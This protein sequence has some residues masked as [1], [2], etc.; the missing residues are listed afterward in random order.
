MSSSEEF[1]IIDSDE[2]G[3]FE[4]EDSESED[5]NPDIALENAFHESK[6]LMDDAHAE[7]AL[8]GFQKVLRLEE[9]RGNPSEYTYDAVGFLARLAFGLGHARDE[10]LGY[11]RRQ[12]EL[13]QTAIVTRNH[14]EK[15]VFEQ[16][17]F[18]AKS[19]DDVDLLEAVYS[20][21]LEALKDDNKLRYKILLK[22]GN[23]YREKD[24]HARLK[25]VLDELYAICDAE[26]STGAQRLEA[27]AL[28]IQMH[29]KTR[30]R[31]K[32]TELYE[33]SLEV[34][35]AISHPRTMGIIRECG[36][37]NNLMMG[38]FE[39]AQRDFFESFKAYDNASDGRAVGC[40]KMYILSSMLC[41]STVDPLAANEV[42][43]YVENREISSFVA[44]VSAYQRDDLHEFERVLRTNRR[45][46]DN[47]LKVYIDDLLK[48]VRTNVI[49]QLIA[50]YTNISIGFVAKK[51][52][53]PDAEVEALLISLILDA[54]ILGYIDQVEQR[55]TLTSKTKSKDETLAGLNRWVSRI[56]SMSASIQGKIR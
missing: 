51:L 42:K 22:L 1:Y 34:S 4:I 19:A 46:F 33:K 50:P 36:G 54:R 52:R 30:N 18:F 23:V 13:G 56:E 3:S 15:C 31:K 27:Y 21:A 55:L 9:E 47:F 40:L 41:E 38:D 2:S 45:S 53:I 39:A 48:N 26:G 16:L 43:G 10:V 12:V 11:F 7:Q 25:S 8:E 24:D 6:S 5:D 20:L 17:D 28:E 32:L 44:L 49:L 14:A 29:T 37:K 35:D